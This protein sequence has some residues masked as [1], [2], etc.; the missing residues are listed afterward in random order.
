MFSAL[1]ALLLNGLFFTL[2]LSDSAGSF[3]KPLKAEEEHRCLE[4]F[5]AGDMEARNTLIE[6]NLRL[7]AHI[8]KNG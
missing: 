1:S 7:V 4:R 3:P 6:H 5:A 8:I 2:R